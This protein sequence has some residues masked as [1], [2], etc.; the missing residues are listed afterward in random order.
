VETWL[1]V[2]MNV[3]GAVVMYV[4]PVAVAA[5]ATSEAA[6]AAAAVDTG[7]ATAIVLRAA[8]TPIRRVRVGFMS[9]LPFDWRVDQVHADRPPPAG[10]APV[11][12]G[13]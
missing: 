10:V 2:L 5:G 7:A 6:V 11:V 3:D 8:A 13:A 12:L 1:L 4:G 9:N